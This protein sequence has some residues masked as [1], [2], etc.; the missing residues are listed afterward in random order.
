MKVLQSLP[1]CSKL[2]ERD[3]F[4]RRAICR[5][6]CSGRWQLASAA[7]IRAEL[8]SL[9]LEHA[10]SPPERHRSIAACARGNPLYVAKKK[11]RNRTE[12]DRLEI[13]AE[14]QQLKVKG[15]MGTEVAA[16]HDL[17][18]DFIQNR[19]G[20]KACYLEHRS[21]CPPGLFTDKRPMQGCHK[22]GVTPCSVDLLTTTPGT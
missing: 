17:G 8:H 18:P 20:A 12:D 1:V 6:R 14:T 7:V 22:A 19:A 13:A 10:F 16:R 9:H 4:E 5:Q 11:G 2:S 21:G 3:G 15:S